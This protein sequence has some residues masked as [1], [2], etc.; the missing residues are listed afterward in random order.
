M[1]IGIIGGTG[2]LNTQ[3]FRKAELE[4]V[5]T[6]YGKVKFLKSKDFYFLQRHRNET[7]PHKLNHRAHIAAFDKIGVKTIIGIGSCGSLKEKI[8][9]GDIVIPDDYI[10]FYNV[11][12]FFDK[13][14]HF[15]VP[16]LSNSLRKKIIKAAKKAKIKVHEKGIYMQTKGPRF[17]TKAEINMFRNYADVLNMTLANE[18]TLAKELGLEYAAICVIDNYCN[19]IGKKKLNAKQVAET[20]KKNQQKVKRLV[21]SVIAELK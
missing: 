11:L 12:T 20:A 2:L 5:L 1:N 14:L 9:P 8:K 6:D 3:L 18:M 21:N 17:E 4:I 15:T 19:G 16:G 13:G 10:N 7:P